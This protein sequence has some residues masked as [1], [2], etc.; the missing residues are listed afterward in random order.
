MKLIIIYE[1]FPCC[2]NIL[3]VLGLLGIGK[4]IDGN[5]RKRFEILTNY[6]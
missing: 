2:Q 6:F 4:Y 5:F 3:T 1:N